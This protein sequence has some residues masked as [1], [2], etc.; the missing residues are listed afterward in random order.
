MVF[1]Q[2]TVAMVGSSLSGMSWGP[3]IQRA[4]DVAVTFAG[5][6]LVYSTVGRASCS[7]PE[8]P[9]CS[10]VCPAPPPC[11][12]GLPSG[13]LDSLHDTCR[14][15]F[16]R[17]DHSCAVILPWALLALVIGCIAG[18]AIGG[19]VGWNLHIRV[20]HVTQL[21]VLPSVPPPVSTG[22]QSPGARA[23]IAAAERKRLAAN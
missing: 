5:R 11:I 17:A 18:L 21:D 4:V 12:G 1:T 8:C 14:A 9:A 19:S 15:A 3:A 23:A 2:W 13:G 16:T 22:V 6:A 10:V 20:G 7:C